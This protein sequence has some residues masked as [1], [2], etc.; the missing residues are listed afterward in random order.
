V[1]G[2]ALMY[3]KNRFITHIITMSA[4]LFLQLRVYPYRDTFSNV[5]AVAFTVCDIVGIV[6]AFFKNVTLQVVFIVILLFV[7]LLVLLPLLSSCRARLGAVGGAAAVASSRGL[8]S[9]SMFAEFTDTW[10]KVL[11]APSLLIAW[12]LSRAAMLVLCVRSRSDSSGGGSGGGGTG[13]TK[14]SPNIS[15]GSGGGGT[16]ITKVSPNI[17]SWE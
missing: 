10:E 11:V 8:A 4:V 2:S 14:V 15:G 12:V 5:S 1:G 13:V 3:P 7:L 17:R 6:S 16:G 9:S